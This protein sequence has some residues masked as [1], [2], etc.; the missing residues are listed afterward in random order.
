[1]IEITLILASTGISIVLYFA[2]QDEVDGFI[3]ALSDLFKS[4]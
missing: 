2:N 3:S 4:K 1:M